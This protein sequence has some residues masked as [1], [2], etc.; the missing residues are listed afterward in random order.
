MAGFL[1]GVGLGLITVLWMVIA[2]L[3]VWRPT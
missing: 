2:A 1:V 3:A